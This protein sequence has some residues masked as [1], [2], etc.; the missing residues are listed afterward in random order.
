MKQAEDDGLVES[1]LELVLGVVRFLGKQ[2]KKKTLA[3]K[4]YNEH[5][6]RWLELDVHQ[7]AHLQVPS[8]R[9]GGVN[10]KDLRKCLLLIL[11]CL[12]CDMPHAS[13][14]VLFDMII[15]EIEQEE[16][17]GA[18]VEF[19]GISTLSDIGLYDIDQLSKPFVCALLELTR[20]EQIGMKL[21]R[22]LATNGSFFDLLR[23]IIAIHEPNSEVIDQL[24]MSLQRLSMNTDFAFSLKQSHVFRWLESQQKE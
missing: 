9:V 1:F 12:H 6:F 15:A 14:R 11:I 3:E 10:E 5:L 2:E 4:I 22:Q 7:G 24:V 16:F 21:A 20:E 17:R 8:R 19:N 23:Q 18:F 13:T